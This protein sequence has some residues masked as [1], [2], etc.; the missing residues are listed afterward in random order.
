MNLC[1]I[2]HTSLKGNRRAIRREP[3]DASNSNSANGSVNSAEWESADWR[4][5]ILGELKLFGSPAFP[6]DEDDGDAE[7]GEGAAGKKKKRVKGRI[8]RENNKKLHPLASLAAQTMPTAPT[9]DELQL[10]VDALQ[11]ACS[12]IVTACSTKHTAKSTLVG[13]T[14]VLIDGLGARLE[15]AGAR[16]AMVRC[17]FSNRILHSRMALDPTHVRFKRTCV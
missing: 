14:T 1:H 16:A 2:G 10:L 8:R 17:S 9:A 7:E 3:H 15:V 4:R 11:R 6:G 12:N 13:T 5:I